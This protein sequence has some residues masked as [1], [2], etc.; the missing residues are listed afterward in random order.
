MG[1][2]AMWRLLVGTWFLLLAIA[3]AD[4]P[5]S[6]EPFEVRS[7]NGRFLAKVT[8]DPAPAST[9]PHLK[10]FSLAV[11]QLDPRAGSRRKLW[12]C[13]YAYSGY[14]GGLVS[15]DGRAFAY[16]DVWFSE[17]RPV[18]D[19]YWEGRRTASVT[20]RAIPFDRSRMT[21]TVSHQLWL[22]DGG[23]TYGRSARFEAK[24]RLVV[25]TCDGKVHYFDPL[26]GRPA[27]N[28]D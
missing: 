3:R 28:R 18:I 27:S 19:F 1:R 25:T 21:P 10:K 9:P 22:V 13:D 5:P 12:R 23:A 24:S 15:D 4:E 11:Y 6:F 26:T 7:V 2:R 16:V 8:A 17:D 14:P 20:G